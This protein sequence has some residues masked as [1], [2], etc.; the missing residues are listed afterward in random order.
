M[1][2]DG[3]RGVVRAAPVFGARLATLDGSP[4]HVQS[5]RQAASDMVARH[6]V[7][8]LRRE[9][10]TWQRV[11]GQGTVAEQNV[12]TGDFDTQLTKIGR[13]HV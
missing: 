1:G 11:V 10:E 13:A 5:M 8:C 9:S 6:E 4:I 12:S 7:L 2:A 3:L